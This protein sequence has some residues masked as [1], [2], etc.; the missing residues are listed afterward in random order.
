MLSGRKESLFIIY[1]VLLCPTQSC[2]L[3]YV[4][5]PQGT[6]LLWKYSIHCQYCVASLSRLRLKTMGVGRWLLWE[7]DR[8][9]CQVE[10][11]L[12]A[13]GRNRKRR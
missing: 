1:L 7:K 3:I 5:L 8:L 10:V 9:E 13:R 12:D 11:H 2:V 6:V 4:S